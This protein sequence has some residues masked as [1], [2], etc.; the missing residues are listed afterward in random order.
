MNLLNI[1]IRKCHSVHPS[2]AYSFFLYI[3]KIHI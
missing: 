1:I 2:H 3:F